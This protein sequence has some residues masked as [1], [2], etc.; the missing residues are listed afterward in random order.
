MDEKFSELE[1]EVGQPI[2]TTLSDQVRESF[3]KIVETDKWLT[4]HNFLVNAGGAAATLGY[5]GTSPS[6]SFAVFPL[7][8]FLVGIIASGIEIRGL[9]SIYSHLH[10]DA[11]RRRGGFVSDEITVREAASVEKIP[12]WSVRANSWSGIVSQISFVVGSVLGISSFVCSVL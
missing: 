5:L 7:L 4:Q 12:K 1:P 11:I 2:L 3:D 10:K 9:L 6:S 8:I